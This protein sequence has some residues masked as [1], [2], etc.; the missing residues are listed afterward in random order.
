MKEGVCTSAIA[1]L[2]NA[3]ELGLGYVNRAEEGGVEASGD[4][5]GRGG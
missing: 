5:A 2:D 1:S 4:G 3:N